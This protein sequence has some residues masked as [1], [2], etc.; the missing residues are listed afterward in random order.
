MLPTTPSLVDASSRSNVQKRCHDIIRPCRPGGLN[1]IITCVHL[2]TRLREI[3][4]DWSQ[5]PFSNFQK[6]PE[7]THCLSPTNKWVNCQGKASPCTFKPRIDRTNQPQGSQVIRHQA[8]STSEVVVILFRIK[9]PRKP[10]FHVD[11]TQTKA[12]HTIEPNQTGWKEGSSV[13]QLVPMAK[14]GQVDVSF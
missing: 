10:T 3:I 11:L 9:Q 8:N 14:I 2:K 6:C 12:P 13:C 4:G 7:L 1:V 5:L